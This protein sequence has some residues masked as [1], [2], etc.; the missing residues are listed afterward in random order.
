MRDEAGSEPPLGEPKEYD[1]P[2][3][4]EPSALLEEARRQKGISDEKVPDVCLLDPDGDIVRYVVEDYDAEPSEHWPG[5]HTDLYLFERN[6]REYGVVGNAVGAPFAVLVAEQLFASGCELLVSVTSA[7]RIEERDDPPYFVLIDSA[8]R[9]EGTSHHY[10]PPSRYAEA[11]PVLVDSVKHSCA[12]ADPTVYTGA[13]WTTDAPFR[14]TETAVEKASSEGILAVEMEAAALYTFAEVRDE[15]VVCFAH[16]TNEMGNR[17]DDFEKGEA[18]G[19]HDALA[20]VDA[21]VRAFFD[22]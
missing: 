10:A 12:D 22:A 7:G 13:T 15:N 19:S 9:D 16:V 8:L 1:E 20:V 11:D 18:G 21:A 4:F 5:Y 3:V 6:G 17:D 2:S 14:E